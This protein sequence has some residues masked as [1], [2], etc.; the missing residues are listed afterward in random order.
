MASAGEIIA[1]L[2]L[3]ER[4]AVELRNYKD[5]PAHF[6]HLR[7]ELDLL[8]ST[9][10][11]ALQLRP[12]SDD[13]RQVLDKVGAI[14]MHCLQPLQALADKMR[15]KDGSLGHFR[16]TRNLVNIGTRVHWSLIARKDV[17][18][19]RKTI[20]AEM[21]AIN[22]LLS[23]QQLTQIKR[24]SS[25]VKGMESAQ[26]ALVEKHS[27][28]LMQQTSSIFSI[29]AAMPNVIADFQTITVEHAAKQSVQGQALQRGLDA[30]MKHM[31]A[32][33]LTTKN[34]WTAAQHHTAAMG[35]MV[36][37]LG[38]LMNDIR[39]LFIFLATC[40]QEMLAAI[41]RNTRLLLDIASQM[42][43]VVHAIEA[44]P[45]SLGVDI[46]RLDDALG[47]TW[48]LPLQA[49]GSWES[50][51]DILRLV[52]FAGRPGLGRVASGQ[53]SITLASSGTRLDP[54]DWIYFVRSDMHI[55]Q[56]MVIPRANTK[57]KECPFPSCAGAILGVDGPKTCSTC[58]RQAT[59]RKRITSV[60]KL[61]NELE[62]RPEEPLDIRPE[63]PGEDLPPMMQLADEEYQHFRRVQIQE[64]VQP[65][66][67]IDE[68]LR[69]LEEDN[70][71]AA[72]NAFI[73]L[74]MLC[75][76][77]ESYHQIE[78]DP[79]H[80]EEATRYL[81]TAI[82]SEPNVAEHW[83]LIGRA[84]LGLGEYPR[85]YE[86]LQQ[87]VYRNGRVPAFW[88]TVGI[89]Y[90]RINQYRDALDAIARAINLNSVQYVTW[91][92]VGV[93]YDKNGN[94]PA[95]AMDAFERCLS[96]C[97]LPQ[98]EARL[99]FL[100]RYT[101]DK[102][103]AGPPPD[104][105]MIHL[106]MESKLESI[107]NEEDHSEGAEIL[108]KPLTASD[109]PGRG[110]AQETDDDEDDDDESAH[111]VVWETTDDSEWESELDEY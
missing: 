33:S 64:P 105:Y 4:V 51:C 32:L 15:T 12:E 63:R 110:R 14:A 6:Q 1:I 8:R 17:D 49:C 102:L 80:F 37:R 52:V 50:F 74:R 93:L 48:G 23:A 27:N 95:D 53:F 85:A 86:A 83:Y 59:I 19:L 39:A 46:I 68:A 7:V 22:M 88:T 96:L 20:L 66:Q 45:R 42:K 29:V 57:P 43:R 104:D 89:L 72:A 54:D 31:E 73:G 36:K 21:V 97:H 11:H 55:E 5:A 61:E 47:D 24:L 28:A 106:M 101:T 67:H 90:Y 30:V 16:T 69:R 13:E 108:I 94:S 71:D 34:T 92:N 2:G 9:L 58:G 84:Y 41:G 109:N 25:A 81:D 111:S 99:Q 18:E 75:L 26:S 60:V 91:R 3:F 77:E 98:V 107:S 82:R 100:Q 62:Q 87:A 38:A 35:R 79:F 40:S 76:A 10:R 44:M 65:V 103:S 56:A 70:T 78:A